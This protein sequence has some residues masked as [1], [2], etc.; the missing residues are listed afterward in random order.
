MRSSG[1]WEMNEDKCDVPLGP[2]LPRLASPCLEFHSRSRCST[3][4]SQWESDERART[5]VCNT[6]TRTH[7]LSLSLTH[8]RSTLVYPETSFPC[9]FLFPS[10]VL[11]FSSFALCPLFPILLFCTCHGNIY[12]HF[13][14]PLFL[15]EFSCSVLLLLLFFLL[16][17]ISSFPLLFRSHTF[18][19]LFTSVAK[20][21][22][23]FLLSTLRRYRMWQASYRVYRKLK[24]IT[25]IAAYN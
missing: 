6:H 19:P 23:Y 4:C 20:C 3:M 5:C 13:F 8:T 16:L 2:A 22:Q 15:G 17:L 25:E 10:S 9:R 24:T 7:T 12:R 1:I 21:L 18:T 14:L 11:P